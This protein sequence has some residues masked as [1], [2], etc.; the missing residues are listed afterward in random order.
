MLHLIEYPVLVKD[1]TEAGA[2][3]SEARPDRRDDCPHRQA[4]VPSAQDGA[5]EE[6]PHS[7]AMALSQRVRQRLTGVVDER[8][9]V[10]LAEVLIARED[11]LRIPDARIQLDLADLVLDELLSE[12][13]NM[14]LVERLTLDLRRKVG[15]RALRLARKALRLT[16]PQV[17]VVVGLL[18]ALMIFGPSGYLVALLANRMLA[19]N[20]LI[21]TAILTEIIWVGLIGAHGS[22]L[23]IV[24]RLPDFGCRQSPM[25]AFFT[26][27]FK[28][29]IGMSFAQ[30]SYALLKSGL[31]PLSAHGG[32][33][34]FIAIGFLAGF[35]ERLA[36]DL[37][38]IGEQAGLGTRPP[39]TG[40]EAKDSVSGP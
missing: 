17:A 21:P 18:G 33:W 11:L 9:Q 12:A 10:L 31:L 2:T 19:D 39:T 20:G 30:L 22:A 38:S 16:H 1:Q 24:V 13:P 40:R 37:V 28:P 26:G 15:G 23:S 7:I 3:P 32:I 6:P 36:K 29:F 8:I 35:S 25:M 5:T 4:V 14:I 27:L 34:L